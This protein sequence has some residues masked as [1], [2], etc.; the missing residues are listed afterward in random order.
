MVRN[1]AL[2]VAFIVAAFMGGAMSHWVLAARA[3][4]AA[5]AAR[6]FHFVDESGHVLCRLTVTESLADGRRGLVLLDEKDEPFPVRREEAT[7]HFIEQR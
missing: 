4:P 3:V 5:V 1:T 7:I 6:E 2:V